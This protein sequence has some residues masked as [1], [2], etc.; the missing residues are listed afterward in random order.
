VAAAVMAATD[1]EGADVLL[2]MS[3]NPQAIDQ[4]F[5]ALRYGGFASLLGIPGR[6]LPSFDLANHIVF[7]GATIY[8]VSGRKMFETWYQTRGLLQTGKVDISPIISHHMPLENYQNAFELMLGGEA[9]KVAL[10][11]NGMEN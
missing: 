8:G 9:D 4:G 10:Y 11:P 1:G 5:G 7:K 2:E 3:G 6:P